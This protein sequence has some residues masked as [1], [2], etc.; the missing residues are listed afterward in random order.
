VNAVLGA[1]LAGGSGARMGRAKAT[2]E[3]AGRPLIC[4]PLAA[5]IEARLETVVVAKRGSEL[6]DLPVP[7]VLEPDEPAH[8]LCG[9]VAALRYADGRSV[10]ACG[11]DMPFVSSALV[12]RIASTDGALVLP[13]MGGR[14]HP[15]LARYGPALLDPLERALEERRPLQETAAQLGPVILDERRLAAYGDPERLLFNVNTPP[16]LARAEDLHRA[17]GS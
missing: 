12:E 6:P 9:I 16:D 10:L 15:L 4:Y 17:G 13:S 3:L 7:L 2:L 1:V 14:L 8:P 11:C 5:L